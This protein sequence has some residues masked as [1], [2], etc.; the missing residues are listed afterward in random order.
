MRRGHPFQAEAFAVRLVHDVPVLDGGSLE[1]ATKQG[2]SSGAPSVPLEG[3]CKNAET[4]LRLT[5]RRIALST[6]DVQ[7]NFT[8]AEGYLPHPGCPVQI[9]ANGNR[10]GRKATPALASTDKL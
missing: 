4:L 10:R 2:S 3:L 9:A 5:C 6:W 8:P 7:F 1:L